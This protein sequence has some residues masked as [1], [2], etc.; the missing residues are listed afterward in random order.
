[1]STFREECDLLAPLETFDPATFRGDADVPQDLCN[2]ILALALIYN[3]CK[4]AIYAHAELATA[5]PEGPPKKTRAWGAF[6][7]AQFHAFR[8]VAGLL[9]ELFELIR[10]N[11]ELLSHSF[12]AS[13]LQQLPSAS[14]EAWAALV[15]VASEAVPT[16]PLGKRLLLLR[17]KVFFHYDQKAIFSGYAQHFLGSTKRDERAYVS[18][19][20]SMRTTRFYFADAAATGYLNVLMGAEQAEAL[21]AELAEI[22]GQV[23]HGLMMI[24]RTFIQ[25]RGSFR[26]E[27]EA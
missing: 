19:G 15:T 7:G 16:D 26:A 20:D 3:D 8:A 18:R 4:D 10:D 23:N 2:F 21:K 12:F 9:H 13:V 6:G 22:I 5:K 11:R 14:R 17:N 25:R 1:M 24:V 27:P